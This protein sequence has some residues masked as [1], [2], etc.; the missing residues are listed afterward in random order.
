MMK[1]NLNN[2]N[3]D[4]D[5]VWDYTMGL[6]EDNGFTLNRTG[7]H[8][9]C[10]ITSEGLHLE[11]TL[12]NTTSRYIV[13]D[14]QTCIEGILETKVIF[15]HFGGHLEGFLVMLST[16]GFT[17]H[18]IRTSNGI[19]RYN[20]NST[21]E[22]IPDVQLNLDVEYV[23][24]IKREKGINYVYVDSELVYQSDKVSINAASHN[25][26]VFQN[27]GEWILK[28]IKFKRIS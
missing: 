16:N 2:E 7:T 10:K 8:S 17:G 1:E 25:R 18:H 23:I 6:P 11:S 24:K 22:N 5:I 19:L 21:F 15:K 14:Y 26:V 13:T 4:W 20:A 3:E 12:A 28:S 27:V 9:I